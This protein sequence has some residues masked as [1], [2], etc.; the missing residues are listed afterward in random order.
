MFTTHTQAPATAEKVATIMS[1]LPPHYPVLNAK[2]LLKGKKLAE[3]LEQLQVLA[4]VPDEIFESLYLKAVNDYAEFV[5]GLPAT[6]VN[7][8]NYHGGLLELGIKRGLQTLARYRKE[9]PIRFPTPDQVPVRQALWSYGLF[10]A[11]LMYGIG[12]I[13]ATYWV[14]LCELTGI[15]QERWN[16]VKGKMSGQGQFYRY[17]FEM[18]RRDELA[19]RSSLVLAL[20][21]LPRAGVS[22]L[23]TDAEIFSAWLAILLDDE[24]HSGLFAK[25]VLPT[26]AELEQQPNEDAGLLIGDLIEQYEIDQNKT[27]KKPEHKIENVRAFDNISNK[28]QPPMNQAQPAEKRSGKFISGREIRTED[29]IGTSDEIGEFFLNWLR[30]YGHKYGRIRGAAGLSQL[31]I[32]TPHGLLISHD[33]LEKFSQENPQ[34]GTVNDIIKQLKN[35][36]FV[37]GQA[38]QQ[39]SNAMIARSQQ[40]NWSFLIDPTA[41]SRKIVGSVNDMVLNIV[42][43]SA[44]PAQQAAPHAPAPRAAPAA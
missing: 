33:L 40:N 23:A 5:Q 1:K 12:Q 21:I 32:T 11:G 19:A 39:A 37:L 26:Q 24:K 20:D 44:Y 25:F 42:G 2:G 6:Q 43:G 41:F 38:Y 22:W 31:L 4:F 28:E 35:S 15:P 14:M 17:S 30:M 18:T 27:D 34:Y 3:M 29:V 8:F 13:I 9:H 7:N 36:A 10:T 16:P